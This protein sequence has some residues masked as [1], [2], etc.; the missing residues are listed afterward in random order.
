MIDPKYITPEVVKRMRAILQAGY[1]ATEKDDNDRVA[2]TV[3]SLAIQVWEDR[4]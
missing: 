2:H 3:L 4:P 1:E